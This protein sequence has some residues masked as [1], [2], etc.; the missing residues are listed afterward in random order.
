VSVRLGITT[1]GGAADRC[2]LGKRDP[3]GDAHRVA[4]LLDLCDVAL[5][6]GEGEFGLGP[7]V[8][9]QQRRPKSDLA[10]SASLRSLKTSQSSRALRCRSSALRRYTGT[11]T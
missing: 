6:C 5:A 11:F 8:G 10:K 1:A 2:G 4:E 7:S 3:S 9:R